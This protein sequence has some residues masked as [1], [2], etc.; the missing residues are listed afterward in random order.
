[1]IEKGKGSVILANEKIFRGVTIC[2]EGTKMPVPNNT[3][4]MRYKNEA[5]KS[6]IDSKQG[7]SVVF[8]D[9]GESSVD[10]FVVCWVLV[11]EKAGFIP[12]VKEIIYN[13][14]NANDI[15]IPFP[16]RDIYVRHLE[17]PKKDV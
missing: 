13:T 16:Q 15:E 14:L 7:F 5:G 3:S 4:F 9:F 11:E 1:M 17:M 12:K 8:N 10:L 6:I 2:V